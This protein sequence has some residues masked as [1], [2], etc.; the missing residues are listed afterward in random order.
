MSGKVIHQ[1]FIPLDGSWKPEEVELSNKLGDIN[2][3]YQEKLN[4]PERAGCFVGMA[5]CIAKSQRVDKDFFL[6][7]VS[8]MWEKIDV[9]MRP[10]QKGGDA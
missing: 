10:A 4:A 8:T 2:I 9:N 1:K 3:D 5:I 6:E 7:L